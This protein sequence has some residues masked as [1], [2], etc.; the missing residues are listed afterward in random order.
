MLNG[1]DGYLLPLSM[2]FVPLIIML[3]RGFTKKKLNLFF[4]SVL[5]INAEARK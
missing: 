5:N 1:W 2:P 3:L 4:L